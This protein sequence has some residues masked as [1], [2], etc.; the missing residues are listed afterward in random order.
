MES[1]HPRANQSVSIGYASLDDIVQE[2][3]AAQQQ[4]ASQEIAFQFE[5]FRQALIK[6][7]EVALY[8]ALVCS[9]LQKNSTLKAPMEF[10]F[11]DWMSRKS[12]TY[13]SQNQN[14]IGVNLENVPVPHGEKGVLDLSDCNLAHR[15]IARGLDFEKTIKYL[16]ETFTVQNSLG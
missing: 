2:G 1:E 9:N 14:V 10:V 8:H 5:E 4:E 13:W 16:L 11:T 3:P 6:G 15:M 7:D 12:F